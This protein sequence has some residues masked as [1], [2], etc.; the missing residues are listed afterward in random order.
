M[1]I[2]G[3]C[4]SFKTSVINRIIQ[5]L[6]TALFI[7]TDELVQNV[8]GIIVRQYEIRNWSTRR[9]P[10][11]IPLPSHQIFSII[12]R[13]LF[14]I[15]YIGA[16]PRTIK[17]R[18]ILF[19]VHVH[20][21]HPFDPVVCRNKFFDFY[22]TSNVIFSFVRNIQLHTMN[23]IRNT[24][25]TPTTYFSSFKNSCTRR[26]QFTDAYYLFATTLIKRLMQS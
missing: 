25:L 26:K 19:E 11:I 13:R 5:L 20:L 14:S 22:F 3:S 17:N 8:L 21:P 23:W 12:V 7:Y 1:S 15:G 9:R 6:N 18:H 2:S 24:P 4:C 16:F 10:G